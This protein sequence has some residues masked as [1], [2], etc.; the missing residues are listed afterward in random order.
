MSWFSTTARTGVDLGL[1]NYLFWMLEISRLRS[2]WQVTVGDVFV[3]DWRGFVV[4]EISGF[5]I[6]IVSNTPISIFL[7]FYA[8]AISYSLEVMNLMV[9]EIKRN[10]NLFCCVDLSNGRNLVC[11]V[12]YRSSVLRLAQQIRITD[13]NYF[14]RKSNYMHLPLWF[15][16]TVECCCLLGKVRTTPIFRWHASNTVS[17]L[18]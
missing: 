5:K 9:W 10:K 6:S 14:I 1:W 2:I 17:I 18:L 4:V 16:T 8:Q 12:T 7:F 3:F 13:R 11:S 15:A